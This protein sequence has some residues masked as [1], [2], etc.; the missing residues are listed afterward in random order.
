MRINKLKIWG[1]ISLIHV[2]INRIN[3]FYEMLFTTKHKIIFTMKQTK[4]KC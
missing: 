2:A 3:E 4:K 1:N